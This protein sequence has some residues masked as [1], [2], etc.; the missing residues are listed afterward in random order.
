MQKAVASLSIYIQALNI[1]IS[2]CL[3]CPQATLCAHF[4]PYLVSF[5]YQGSDVLSQLHPS[6]VE[7]VS[8]QRIFLLSGHC[9]YRERGLRQNCLSCNLR[10]CGNILAHLCN[11]RLA[12]IFINMW[13]NII[14]I[15]HL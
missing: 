13:Q 14:P 15:R 8:S 1:I 7:Y 2:F 4:T 5:G 9:G 11:L 12:E 10:T 6:T 3:P